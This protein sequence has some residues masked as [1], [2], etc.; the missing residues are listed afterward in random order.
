M[1]ASRWDK[2]SF[3]KISSMAVQNTAY[4]T[5][6]QVRTMSLVAMET[7]FVMDAIDTRCVFSPANSRHEY[8]QVRIPST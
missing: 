6:L 2:E 8:L 1:N 5:Q 4:T 7:A 3:R